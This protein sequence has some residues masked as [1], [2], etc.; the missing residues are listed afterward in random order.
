MLIPAN[1]AIISNMPVNDYNK[2]IDNE[3]GWN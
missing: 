2:K 1:I 3:R